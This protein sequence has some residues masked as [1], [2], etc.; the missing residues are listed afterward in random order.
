MICTLFY[1]VEYAAVP[2]LITVSYCLNSATPHN[3]SCCQKAAHPE[4]KQCQGKNCNPGSDCCLNCPFCYVTL[5]PA[6]TKAPQ[7]ASATQEYNEWSSS[8]IYAY[9]GSCWK[10]PN[11]A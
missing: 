1:L 11:R 2:R 3:K 10:P 9:H 5:L 4:K 6:Q 7:Q 8:Y